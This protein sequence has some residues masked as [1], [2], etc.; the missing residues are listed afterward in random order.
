VIRRIVLVGILVSA[1]V[2][3]TANPLEAAKTPVKFPADVLSVKGLS[4]PGA[5]QFTWCATSQTCV[6]VGTGTSTGAVP[7]LYEVTESKGRV[8]SSHVAAMPSDYVA[9]AYGGAFLS[10]LSCVSLSSCLV[11]G[12]YSV[13]NGNDGVFT[14]QG[15]A[16]SW[17]AVTPLTGFPNPNTPQVENERG[18]CWAS[19]ECFVTGEY[20]GTLDGGQN[21][22]GFSDVE[23]HGTFG[24]VTVVTLPTTPGAEG[25]DEFDTLSCSLTDPG[26]CESVG[27]YTVNNVRQ[28]FGVTFLDGVETSTSAIPAPS[29]YDGT[30]QPISASTLSCWT[31]SSCIAAGTYT[32]TDET[33]HEWR[34]V[35]SLSG[36]G[37][38]QPQPLPSNYTQAG[39]QSYPPVAACADNGTCVLASWANPS[40]TPNTLEPLLVAYV[41]GAFRS[42]LVPDPAA[43][44]N[45][46]SVVC[47]AGTC[48]LFGNEGALKSERNVVLLTESATGAFAKPELLTSYP[49]TLASKNG[50]PVITSAGCNV[51][52]LCTAAASFFTSKKTE[53][54]YVVTGLA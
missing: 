49:S 12:N 32:S 1:G 53:S 25:D 40:A 39:A 3:A 31:E 8:L 30:T 45:V 37:E 14:W 21:W 23:S 41:N 50:E 20:S 36:W 26:W 15:G 48:S 54:I 5:P 18:A 43:R 52:N 7:V 6:V 27:T 24:P 47:G 16:T 9:S 28:L 22:T 10:S 11:V 4:S 46:S 13:A 17:G 19:G 38:A 2:V 42:P 35:L 51:D 29:D 34:A 44:L 33:T